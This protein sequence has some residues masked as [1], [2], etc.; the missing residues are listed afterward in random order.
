MA[1]ILD[2]ETAL[3]SL[4]GAT[5]YPLGTGQPSAAG[6][7]CKIY[8]GWP[9]SAEL[10]I[11]LAAGV[12][13]ISVYSG[14]NL[15]RV[16]TRYSREWTDLQP[17]VPTV[18]AVVSNNVVTIGGSVTTAH[19]VTLVIDGASYSYAA[20]VTDTLA[21]VAAAL[22]ALI[23]SALVVSVVGAVITL[24]TKTAGLVTARTGAPGTVSRELGRQQ[25]GMMVSIWAPSPQARSAISTLLMTAVQK[26]D[27]VTLPDGSQMWLT[28]R[29]SNESDGTENAM[30]YRRDIQLWAE[31]ATVET[32]TGYPIT[33]TV[34]TVA[35]APNIPN[36]TAPVT[37]TTAQ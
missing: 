10:A 20:L 35:L 18:T 25:R 28:Y 30:A 34:N 6:I 15:E 1:D 3:A 7:D 33:T 2:I 14:Q 8:P 5:I 19:Y 16:T 31:Y 4:C 22:A 9:S 12:A 23:P 13:E 24:A 37:V 21:T 36:A 17:T 11:S 32:A 26:N 27:F 29:Q